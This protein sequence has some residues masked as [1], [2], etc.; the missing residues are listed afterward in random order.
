MIVNS[1]PIW[2]RPPS[3]IRSISRAKIPRHMS[4]GDRAH[5]A[6]AI[7]RR[8]RQRPPRRRNHGKRN[9]MR[10]DTQRDTLQARACGGADRRAGGERDHKSERP[11]PECFGKP[12]GI[13]GKNALFKRCFKALDMG[14]ERIGFW[15][16]LRRINAGDSRVRGR[17]GGQAVNRLGRKRDETAAPQDARRLGNA[18]RVRR[19][20]SL[21]GG[22]GIRATKS[23]FIRRHSSLTTQ[24]GQVAY[25]SILDVVHPWHA[26]FFAVKGQ[27]I[28]GDSHDLSRAHCRHSFRHDP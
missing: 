17:V 21:R 26:E 6:G 11:R 8:R 5:P 7:G 14:D 4:G 1:R 28:R 25:N 3:R 19:Q 24:Q 2:Q 18:S 9:W 10:W 23:L 22:R 20:F 16:C 13:G 12:H 15:P 27:V